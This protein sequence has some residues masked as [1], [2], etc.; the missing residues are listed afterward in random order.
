[1]SGN[2]VQMF[3]IP[4]H[5]WTMNESVEEISARL[6]EPRF[7]QHVVINVAKLVALQHDTRLREAVLRCDI[8]NV[9]G[10]GVVW[11][12]RL[13][14]LPIPE[15]VAGID[16]FYELLGLAERRGEPVYFLGA[17][18]D[19]I[20]KAVENLRSQYPS[21]NVVG[22]HHGYFWDDAKTVVNDIRRSGATMLFVAITSPKKEQFI[23]HWRDELGVKFAMGVG[24]TFD[25]VAGKTRRAP[26]WMQQAGQPL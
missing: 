18:T 15:R 5:P 22:W 19:V 6:N 8:V 16:L 12:G 13:L 9:D 10:M 14:G 20:T 26:V 23:H 24:G 21:L 7:T 4:M 3:G 17:K 11:G 1:M 25:I 2:T